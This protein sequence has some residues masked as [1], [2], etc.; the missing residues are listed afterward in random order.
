ME[1][2]LV[3]AIPSLSTSGS[4]SVWKLKCGMRSIRQWMKMLQTAEMSSSKYL[5][6]QHVPYVTPTPSLG[7]E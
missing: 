4:S 2:K 3:A 5:C 1:L 7:G 6:G